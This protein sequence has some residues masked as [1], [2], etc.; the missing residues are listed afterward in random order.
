MFTT[1]SKKNFSGPIPPLNRSKRA[2][3]SGHFGV[4]SLY[5]L[6]GRFLGRV[7]LDHFSLP[8][9]PAISAVS[10]TPRGEPR[11]APWYCAVRLVRTASAVRIRNSCIMYSCIMSAEAVC[12]PLT[13]DRAAIR[14]RAFKPACLCNWR[15]DAVSYQQIDHTPCDHLFG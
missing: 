7:P 13:V 5:E 3:N 6:I 15:C 9:L 8:H 14:G 10:A 2:R 12:S 11:A 4:G 1:R